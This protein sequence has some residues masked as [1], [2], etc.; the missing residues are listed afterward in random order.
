MGRT[1]GEDD[2]PRTIALLMSPTVQ[3][4]NGALIDT[5]ALGPGVA[6]D[7]GHCLAWMDAWTYMEE[8]GKVAFDV[9]YL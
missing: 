7:A 5:C 6:F 8:G 3:R 9:A 1:W 2:L 4:S